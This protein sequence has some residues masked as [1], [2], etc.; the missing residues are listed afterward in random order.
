MFGRKA[1]NILIVKTDSLGAFVAAEPVFAAIRQS[2]PSAR[3][4]LI[5][6]ASLQ[7][8]ARAAPYFDQVA[9]LP[10][11][12]DAAAR[13]AFVKQLKSQRFTHIFDLSA[14]DAARKLQQAMGPFGPKWL[15]AAPPRRRKA[16][17][18]DLSGYQKLADA[19]GLAFERRLPDFSWALEARKDSA[20]MQ[21]SWFGIS[22]AF[23]LLMPGP[24][25]ARRWP[26]GCYARLAHLMARAGVM[27]VLAGGKDIHAFGDE[28]AHEAPEVVDLSGKTDHLQLVALAQES[29]FFVTDSAE[30]VQLALS[31]G[32]RGVMIARSNSAA[33]PEGRNVVLVTAPQDLGEAK[34]ELVWRTLQNMGLTPEAEPTKRAARHT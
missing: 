3:I 33:P 9:S 28:M 34:A 27:P 2:F 7:R 21:P 17:A 32:C 16:G 12:S 4:S 13:T 23:G 19:A 14:D 11:L 31:V 25:L 1:G 20:N 29:A 30:E 18:G 8:I 22:G 15:A 5:T 10:D 24:D 6:Q 26:V